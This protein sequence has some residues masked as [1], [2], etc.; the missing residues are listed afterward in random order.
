[1]D[2]LSNDEMIKVF[3]EYQELYEKE[4]K[5]MKTKLLAT[6]A[7]L[8]YVSGLELIHHD[9]CD[10]CGAPTYIGYWENDE[11][12]TNNM[13]RTNC[14]NKVICDGC[15]FKRDEDGNRL[16]RIIK[17]EYDGTKSDIDCITCYDKKHR[18]KK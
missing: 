14:C 6:E 11:G 2:K 9:T 15:F 17:R 4:L 7:A 13:N 18:Y 1:M 8:Q 3:I 16:I 10:W 12:L 5:I